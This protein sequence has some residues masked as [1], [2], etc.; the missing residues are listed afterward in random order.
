[1]TIFV[2]KRGPQVRNVS[3]VCFSKRLSLIGSLALVVYEK[4]KTS[5]VKCGSCLPKNLQEQLPWSKQGTV[6]ERFVSIHNI[7]YIY[8][9]PLKMLS[10]TIKSLF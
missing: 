7:C 1:M 3:R 10:Q 9:Q 6:H 8:L 2:E 5:E 4:H